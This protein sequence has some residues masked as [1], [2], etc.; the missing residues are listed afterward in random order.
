M[1]RK[2]E[3]LVVLDTRGKEDTVDSLV[4]KI[5]RE[6]ELEGAKLEQIDHV[7]KRRFP[8]GSKGLTDG[9]YVCYQFEAEPATIDKVRSKLKLTSEVHQQHYQVRA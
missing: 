9:Y 7:G 1:K 8:Y 5:G 4:S 2:Y 3:S 6:M